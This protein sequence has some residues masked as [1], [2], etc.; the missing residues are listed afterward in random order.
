M[1]KIIEFPINRIQRTESNGYKNLKALFEICSSVTTCNFYLESVEE[2]FRKAQITENEM[3]TL[4]RIGRQKRLTLTNSEQEP[5]KAEKPG[6]YLYTLEMGQQEPA[7]CQMEASL[8]YYGKHYFIDTPLELKG[9]G[10][11]F[12]RKYSAKDFTNPNNKKIGW[13]EYQVT[14]LAYEKL[15]SQYAI[16]YKCSL[17]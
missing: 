5:Q 12:I 2:L 4:R 11:S 13:N 9:R 15:K 16:S 1:S 17:D 8:S 3:L 10:I 14:K 7:G 6:T